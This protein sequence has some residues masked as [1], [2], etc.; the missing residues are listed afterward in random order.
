MMQLFSLLLS[1]LLLCLSSFP[2][3][4]DDALLQQLIP[5]TKSQFLPVVV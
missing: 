2:L 5:A 1:I 3:K 4:A